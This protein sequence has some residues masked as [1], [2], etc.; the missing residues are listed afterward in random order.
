MKTGLF[1]GSYNPIHIGHLIIANYMATQS[2]LGEVWMVVSPHNPL[3]PKKTLA[4][5][6]DRLHLV[7]LAI[8]ENERLKASNI[9]F[10]LPQP[11]YTADT[12]TYLREKYPNR[13]FVLIMGADNLATLHRWKNYE[14][15]LRNY[16]I[17]VYDRE[18]FGQRQF[19]DFPEADIRFF[20]APLL[21]ISA[22][23]IRDCIQNG[24]SI[25]YLVPEKVFQYIEKNNLYK[26]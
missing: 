21:Q 10:Q 20:K 15:L 17:Y 23:Y 26:N 2:D 4:N 8:E 24:H 7:H 1:F 12:L 18:D 16:P 22:T 13:A 6:Y 11:S 5:D 9:E 14:L 3:K 25:R 19:P